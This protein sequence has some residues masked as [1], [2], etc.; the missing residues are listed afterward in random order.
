MYVP[1]HNEMVTLGVALEPCAC[2]VHAITT[3]LLDLTLNDKNASYRSQLLCLK[4]SFMVH[5]INATF[6]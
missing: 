4:N 3:A 1:P 2:E 6:F 5:P